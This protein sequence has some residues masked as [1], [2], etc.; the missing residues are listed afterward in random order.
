VSSW[1]QASP[2]SQE[3]P[4][5]FGW[6]THSFAA[7]SHTP[8][9]QAPPADE[10]SRG[11]PPWQ[12]P[13]THTSPSVQKVPSL[14]APPSASMRQLEEQQSPLIPLPSSHS[15]PAS[16]SPLPQ[17]APPNTTSASSRTATV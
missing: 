5:S 6:A 4:S 16:T 3:A 11:A 8:S 13:A 10:Q 1:V 17:L 15:S 2:S 12:T 9:L 7:S 14:H